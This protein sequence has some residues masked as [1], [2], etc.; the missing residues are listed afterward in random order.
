MLKKLLWD[1]ES[2]IILGYMVHYEI[3]ISE[4]KNF[5]TN[6]KKKGSNLTVFP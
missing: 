4:S 5:L 1:G 3:K 2:N 6:R